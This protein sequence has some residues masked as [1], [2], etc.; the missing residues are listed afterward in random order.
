MLIY[1]S[2]HFL[3]VPVSDA[4][5]QEIEHIFNEFFDWAERRKVTVVLAAGNMVELPLH[6]GAPQ[7][8][9]TKNNH[10]ITV[11]GVREDGSLYPN[12][13][14]QLP[15]ELGSLTVFAPAVNII[16]PGNGG[17]LHIDTGLNTGTSQ[18][19]AITVSLVRAIDHYSLLTFP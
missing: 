14:P 7:K 10:I 17:Q 13:S 5:G 8:F 6:K 12:T 15:G 9:G 18:A 4:R 16:A 19:A 2:S 11:G 3:G 1:R